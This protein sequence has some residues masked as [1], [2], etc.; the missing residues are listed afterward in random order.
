MSSEPSWN[1]PQTEGCEWSTFSK[2]LCSWRS[3]VIGIKWYHFVS[4]DEEQ[5]RSN[6]SALNEH[7]GAWHLTLFRH[8]AHTDNSVGVEQI[9]LCHHLEDTSGITSHSVDENGS[10]LPSPTNRHGLKQSVGLWTNHSGGCW[11]LVALCTRIDAFNML[12]MFWGQKASE[13]FR[14]SWSVWT[15]WGSSWCFPCHSWRGWQPPAPFSCHLVSSTSCSFSL[16]Y[17]QLSQY[18][19]VFMVEAIHD[20]QQMVSKHWR[21]TGDKFGQYRLMQ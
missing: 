16:Q 6:W 13:C 19:C 3:L 9:L 1:C 8:I 5:R 2:Q 14:Q 18:V 7:I 17:Y 10:D 21:L 11:Q 20:A 4:S 15:C 12:A